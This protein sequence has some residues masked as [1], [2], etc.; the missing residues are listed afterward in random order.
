[1]N[2][3]TEKT[4]V[5]CVHFVF[6]NEKER[7]LM[8]PRTVTDL[9]KAGVMITLNG[10]PKGELIQMSWEVKSDKETWEG[11]TELSNN[12]KAMAHLIYGLSERENTDC[13][14]FKKEILDKKSVSWVEI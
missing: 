6:V 9:T 13:E 1:M 12:I 2:R 10:K 8:N 11:R 3:D 4:K 7:I 14:I 5:Y